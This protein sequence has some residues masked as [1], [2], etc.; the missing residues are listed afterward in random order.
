MRPESADIATIL[1]F[2]LV[3]GLLYLALPLAINGVVGNL[4]FGTQSVSYT[5]LTLP[6]KRIV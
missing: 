3:T 4:A 2:S 6:T 1:I 5:H